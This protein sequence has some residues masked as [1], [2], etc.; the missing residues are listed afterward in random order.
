MIFTKVL[1]LCITKK[2]S[3]LGLFFCILNKTCIFYLNSTK[4]NKTN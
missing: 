3:N 4:S 2:L 1:H